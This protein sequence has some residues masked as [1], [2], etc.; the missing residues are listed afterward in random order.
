MVRNKDG[1]KVVRSKA[2][3]ST[4]PLL[5][6]LWVRFIVPCNCFNVSRL[7]NLAAINSFDAVSCFGS[8]AYMDN[9]LLSFLCGI[10][11]LGREGRFISDAATIMDDIINALIKVDM[12]PLHILLV[13]LIPLSKQEKLSLFPNPSNELNF[14]V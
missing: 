11:G 6:G 7:E 3:M 4:R 13:L 14:F 10:D 1:N 5:I 9:V 2:E 8:F 12:N